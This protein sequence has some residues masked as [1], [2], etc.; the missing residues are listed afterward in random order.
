[1]NCNTNTIVFKAWIMCNGNDKMKCWEKKNRFSVAHKYEL[2]AYIGALLIQLRMQSQSQFII[3]SWPLHV[4][5]GR[6]RERERSKEKKTAKPPTLSLLGNYGARSWWFCCWFIPFCNSFFSFLVFFRYIN[7][8][9]LLL[10]DLQ[11]RLYM[12]KVKR[13]DGLFNPEQCEQQLVVDLSFGFFLAKGKWR[14]PAA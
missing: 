9:E 8:L 1:M 3:L 6:K 13:K 14:G 5:E 4:N 2:H 12:A 11:N 7:D 10:N